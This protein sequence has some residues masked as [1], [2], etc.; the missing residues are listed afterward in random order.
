MSLKWMLDSDTSLNSTASNPE[1]P[2]FLDLF[3]V[4]RPPSQCTAGSAGG[5]SL[6]AMLVKKVGLDPPV[7][8]CPGSCA[9]SAVAGGH[10]A[11]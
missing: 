2:S 5:F 6:T 11:H 9:A 3:G 4:K 1:P 8:C 10:V 7:G